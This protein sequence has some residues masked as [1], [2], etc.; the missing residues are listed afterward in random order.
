MR[1]ISQAICKSRLYVFHQALLRNHICTKFKMSSSSLDSQPI[2]RRRG[3]SLTPEPTP[4]V[5]ILN[6]PILNS[7]SNRKSFTISTDA[8]ENPALQ[9][10]IPVH[11]DARSGIA[12]Y[13]IKGKYVDWPP[14]KHL[15]NSISPLDQRSVSVE[16]SESIT[17]P[18][19]KESPTF[20]LPDHD[21][22]KS[23]LRKSDPLGRN[24][25][26][27]LATKLLQDQIIMG[28]ADR[29]G[30]ENDSASSCQRLPPGKPLRSLQCAADAPQSTVIPGLYLAYH[31][32]S[33]AMNHTTLSGERFTHIISLV[34]ITDPSDFT[35]TAVEDIAERSQIRNLSTLKLGVPWVNDSIAPGVGNER[36][37]LRLTC[38]Q[39]AMARN[40]IALNLP[41]P[42]HTKIHLG[43]TLQ[44]IQPWSAHRMLIT[45]PQ[46]GL[47]LEREALAIMACYLSYM[48]T[49]KEKDV[50]REQARLF[51]LHVQACRSY[52]DVWKQA[53]TVLKDDT[54]LKVIGSGAEMVTSPTEY[55]LYHRGLFTE[56]AAKSSS[57]AT[58]AEKISD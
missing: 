41:L 19:V 7:S 44:P 23:E 31:S 55:S 57:S 8:N 40:Y 26:P 16:K 14:R 52:A 11:V 1:G 25:K 29:S 6:F 51:G 37:P 24:P 18:E 50:R 38:R 20:L 21:G 53:A 56:Y 48:S 15:E 5:S 35:I 4:S 43:R 12:T 36:H 28:N 32:A 45:L 10:H 42:G 27:H 9:G 2:W 47:D 30:C 46:E 39:L 34:F 54:E 17:Q 13:W 49:A 22:T 58:H 3:Q 33:S